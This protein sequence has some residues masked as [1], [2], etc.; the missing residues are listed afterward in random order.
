LLPERAARVLGAPAVE[1]I[2]AAAGRAS[3]TGT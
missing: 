2:L 3:V 1:E